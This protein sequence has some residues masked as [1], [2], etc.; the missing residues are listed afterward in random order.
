MIYGYTIQKD[1]RALKT[2]ISDIL[3]ITL[4]VLTGVIIFQRERLRPLLIRIETLL[5]KLNG[6]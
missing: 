6:D 5:T 1:K 2:M 4:N 3:L